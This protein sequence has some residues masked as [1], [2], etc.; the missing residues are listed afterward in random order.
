M[1][2]GDKEIE[3]RSVYFEIDKKPYEILN[4]YFNIPTPR[5]ILPYYLDEPHKHLILR[6]K[7]SILLGKEQTFA[8]KDVL[9]ELCD[10]EHYPEQPEED[11]KH[12]YKPPNFL[13]HTLDETSAN[14]KIVFYRYD[15]RMT[16]WRIPDRW[17]RNLDKK[18]W[19]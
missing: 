4:Q 12:Y 3:I 7:K 9:D 11:D 5:M 16:S 1:T 18:F 19:G 8:G 2:G 15:D 17:W 6:P 14:Y 13:K 10:K